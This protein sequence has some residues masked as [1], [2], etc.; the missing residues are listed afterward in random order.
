MKENKKY[1]IISGV[2]FALAAVLLLV[3]LLVPKKNASPSLLNCTVED[4]T[5]DIGEEKTDFYQLSNPNADIQFK[6]D[7]SDIIQINEERV[8]GVKAGVVN[9]EMVL[10][11]NGQTISEYFKV[12]VLAEDYSLHLIPN[13]NCSFSD[14]RL[15]MA[16][17]VC[18]FTLE[19]IDKNGQ[20]ITDKAIAVST[21]N[22][23]SCTMLFGVYRLTSTG[24]C[25]ITFSVEELNFETIVIVNRM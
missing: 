17:D 15:M 25:V 4:I 10:T 3:F 19:M 22:G 21:S 14:G 8:V 13:E 5:I 11:L 1:Y 20:L 7:K 24:D 12:T 16:Q 9:V 2:I 18:T 6:F 23:A